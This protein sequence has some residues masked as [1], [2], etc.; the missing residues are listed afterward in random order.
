MI[1]YREDDIAMIKMML[2]QLVVQGFTQ[3]RLL[4]SVGSIL[5]KGVKTEE[6]EEGGKDGSR[7]CCGLSE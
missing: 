2:E 3:A 7:Q 1:Q 4:A 6:N 5:E